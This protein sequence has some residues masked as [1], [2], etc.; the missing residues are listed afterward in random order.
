MVFGPSLDIGDTRTARPKSTCAVSS[1]HPGGGLLGC[2]AQDLGEVISAARG[3][4]D[5]DL[6]LSSESVI[7]L[8]TQKLVSHCLL[9]RDD[10]TSGP[11]DRVNS[12]HSATSRRMTTSASSGTKRIGLNVTAPPRHL[13]A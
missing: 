8:F 12:R 5:A 9:E 6:P 10:C 13:T 7:N 4:V 2:A 3:A 11:A 1:R